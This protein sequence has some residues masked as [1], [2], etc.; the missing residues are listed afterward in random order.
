MNASSY[1]SRTR[2]Q[3]YWKNFAPNLE[4]MM[5]DKSASIIHRD[6][7]EEICSLLPSIE[8][9]HVLELGAGIGRYTGLLASEADHVTAVDF[10][11]EYINTN[12]INNTNL[13]NITYIAADVLDL[14]LPAK[15]FGAVFSNW[16]LMYLTD[17][18]CV[19]LLQKILHWLDDSGWL[20]FRE[21]CFH[22][23]G[24]FYLSLSYK[25]FLWHKV[26]FKHKNNSYQIYFLA[27]KLEKN[28]NS[29]DTNSK[30][31]F[32]A[33]LDNKQYSRNGVRRYEWIFGKTFLSTGGMTTTKKYVSL[34]DLKPGQKVLDVGCGIG[35]HSFYMAEKHGVEVLGVDLSV[36][37][38]TV[39]TEYLSE[40]PQLADKVKFVICDVTR[41]IY[42]DNAFDTIYSR[43]T[44]LHIPNKD[45]LF[46]NFLKWL[47][48]GGKILFT[49]Y[50]RSEKEIS[51]NFEAYI[52]DRGYNLLTT[53]QYKELLEKCGFI[54][55]RS[56]DATDEFLSALLAE[57]N[58]L[59]D[60]K[61]NFLSEFSE[62]DYKYLEENWTA[63]IK[64]V[65]EGNQTWTVC[66][67][68]K[69]L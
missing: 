30:D 34:L 53:N 9:K 55:I 22:S 2:M 51:P 17:Q 32:Q 48:P 26:H 38:M 12:E 19:A 54:N 67:A 62:A 18:E 60:E 41:S 68:E 64:R 4:S 16:L 42:D 37:M 56:E 65:T 13:S 1:A 10:M 44:L 36:N 69:P 46:T 7:Q 29:K 3:Q 66:Y 23:S 50:S 45:E 58:K 59:R 35:G 39:A 21:S 6:E 31:L 27:K 20:F 43:D 28:M 57:L 52:K 33:F 24:N 63:K 5:L 11:E 25:T 47:K 40:K 14:Q 61:E 49:D 8:G 15:K